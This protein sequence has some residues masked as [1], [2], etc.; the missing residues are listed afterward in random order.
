MGAISASCCTGVPLNALLRPLRLCQAGRPPPCGVFV[1]ELEE[2]RFPRHSGTRRTVHGLPGPCRLLSHS[3]VVLLVPSHTLLLELRRERCCGVVEGLGKD[4]AHG[5]PLVLQPRA[6]PALS[7]LLVVLDVAGAQ[8]EKSAA[9]SMNWN[10][11][12]ST[13]PYTMDCWYLSLM[14][15]G[16]VPQPGDNHPPSPPQPCSSVL[17]WVAQW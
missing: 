7:L 3:G 4:H 1:V 6:K 13:F 14:I 10:W 16:D 17:Y 12:T 11:G 9:L 5:L 8:Q 2:H 15:T